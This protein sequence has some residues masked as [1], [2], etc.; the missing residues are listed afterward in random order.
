MT[1][2]SAP[3]P[4][5]GRPSKLT[6]QLIDALAR[7]VKAGRN[8][9][10]AATFAGI[11]GGTFA[12]YLAVGRKALEAG[13]STNEFE[14]RC[15]QLRL[16][17]SEADG[18]VKGEQPQVVAPQITASVITADPVAAGAVTSERVGQAPTREPVKYVI[19]IGKPWPRSLVR[20]AISTMSSVLRKHLV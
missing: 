1:N 18:A 6:P 12:R 2:T 4:T 14:V 19:T 11:S 8:R 16:R 15:A 17:I 10:D 9:G 20:R 7:A 5:R 3:S 13:G